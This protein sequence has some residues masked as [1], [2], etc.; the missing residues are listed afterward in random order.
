MRAS[1]GFAVAAA[2]MMGVLC[3]A[4]SAFA[5]ESGSFS[6]IAT[7][8]RDFTSIEHADG[9]FFG[10]KLEGTITT[11]ASSGEPF[12]EGGHSLST[13][14]IFGKRSAAG[15]DLQTACTI[16]QPLRRHAL[17]YVAERRA[18]DVDGRRRRAGSVGAGR[19]HRCLCRAGRKLCL[20]DQLSGQQSGR[21]D[22]GL[23]LAQGVIA[24]RRRVP[25]RGL[26]RGSAEPA[27][28]LPR[29]IPCRW[30]WLW[31]RQRRPC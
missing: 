13:C 10:G 27:T 6:A 3:A 24:A 15:L 30:R 5:Q 18:G 20:R 28:L 11:L 17:S 16:H 14:V 4:P 23:H 25:A 26:A 1:R 12:V 19:R 21:H 29:V 8:V 31:A 2:A 7:Y 22:R 9:A